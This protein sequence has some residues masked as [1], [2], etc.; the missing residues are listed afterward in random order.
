MQ[1]EDT[2]KQHKVSAI[3]VSISMIFDGLS[4][5]IFGFFY[6]VGKGNTDFPDIETKK[7]LVLQGEIVAASAFIYFLTCLLSLNYGLR[8]SRVWSDIILGLGMIHFAGASYLLTVTSPYADSV[9]PLPYGSIAVNLLLLVI[10]VYNK[11]KSALFA[12]DRNA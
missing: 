1:N 7:A 11:N 5:L 2:L 6:L 9:Y 4:M 10:I 3:V 12:K 8:G